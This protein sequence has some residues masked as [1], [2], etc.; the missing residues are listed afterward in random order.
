MH[1]IRFF[2]L[3]IMT[4]GISGI[5]TAQTA[6]ETLFDRADKNG[7]GVIT[8]EE[9]NLPLAFRRADLNGDETVTREEFLQHA[10]RLRK[11]RDT[12][13]ETG[14][15][16]RRDIEYARIDGVDPNLH[17]LDVYWPDQKCDAPNPVMVF[18]HGGAW[19]TGDKSNN[20][21]TKAEWFTSHGFVFV[22]VNYRLSP[23][24]TH[25][26]HI[27]DVASAIAWIQDNAEAF[28]GNPDRIFVMG[29]SAGAHLANLVATDERRLAAHGL[30]ASDLAGIISLDTA[31]LDLVNSSPLSAAGRNIRESAFG[32]MNGWKDASPISFIAEADELPPFLMFSTGSQNRQRQNDAF[33]EAIRTR[34]GRAEHVHADDRTHREINQMLGNPR[35]PYTRKIM[36][37]T[38]PP[39]P[40]AGRKIVF[41]CGD[42]EYRSEESM[43]MLAEIIHRDFGGDIQVCHALAEDGTIDPNRLDHIEGLEAVKDADL[44]VMYTRFRALPDDQLKIITDHAA[45][46]KPMVG[47]RTATHAFRYPGD[48]PHAKSMNNEW[49]TQVFGQKW[50]TH[51]GHHGDNEQRLTDVTIREEHKTHPTLRG[52]EPFKAYSWLYH[53]DGGGDRLPADATVLTM[54]HSLISG[55]ERSGRTD[56][57]PLDQ[58]VSWI[59]ERDEPGLPGRVFFSTTAHPY[60]FREPS[61]RRHAIQGILWAL[62]HE[63]LIP[64]GGVKT[65]IVGVYEP[66]PSGFGEVFRAGVRPRPIGMSE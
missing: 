34:G 16:V 5:S 9:T 19:R 12:Q 17:S 7:D 49:P 33:V 22:T 51:H 25:P 57:F 29:H 61:M 35:D 40:L 39:Q 14:Y 66:R 53:V 54:G 41:I 48:S 27:E 24:A 63:E 32:P 43:P 28:C 52:V 60:D 10:E 31:T 15:Q 30:K 37:F 18:I 47:F 62:G 13:P 21:R 1:P 42:E 45:S 11:S 3:I 64:E 59:M 38:E 8:P 44:V 46:G 2:F 58:P 4:L 55:H 23:A 36:A 56:R 20:P 50:I 6:A 65:D 26:A